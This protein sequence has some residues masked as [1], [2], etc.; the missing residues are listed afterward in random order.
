MRN[1]HTKRA[2]GHTA[3]T[4]ITKVITKAN[5]GLL[6]KEATVGRVSG[7]PSARS[8]PALGTASLGAGKAGSENPLLA[9]SVSKT[10]VPV[11]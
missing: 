4:M 9:G 3:S 5:S 2:T 11:H 8:E 6:A 7:S 1:V 10:P